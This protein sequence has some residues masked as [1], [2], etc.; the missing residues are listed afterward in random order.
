MKT[1]LTG[2]HLPVVGDRVWHIF[3]GVVRSGPVSKV[4]PPGQPMGYAAVFITENGGTCCVHGANP[5]VMNDTDGWYWSEAEAQAAVDAH[6]AWQA[7]IKAQSIRDGV[8]SADS[9]LARV[10]VT[11]G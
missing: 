1:S 6:N 5:S 2:A 4:D 9:P 8:Y 11:A 10:W 7:S 3:H